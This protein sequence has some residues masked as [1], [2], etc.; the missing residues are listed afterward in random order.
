MKKIAG[1]DLVSNNEWI[2]QS[3]EPKKHKNKQQRQGKEASYSNFWDVKAP[4]GKTQ[5]V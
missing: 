4:R 3:T 5:Y 1:A 2:L